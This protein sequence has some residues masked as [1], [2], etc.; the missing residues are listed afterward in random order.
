MEPRRFLSYS[1]ASD[2]TAIGRVSSAE[3]FV[4]LGSRL[5]FRGGGELWQTDGTPGSTGLLRDI[6]PDGASDPRL[7]TVLNG[8]AFFFATDPAHGRELW[9]TDGTTDG[10]RL[11][12]DITPGPASTNAL[13]MA[14]VNGRLYFA[15]DSG[16]QQRPWVSDGTAAGTY[17]LLPGHTNLFG[18]VN[19]FFAFAGKTYFFVGGGIFSIDGT[20]EGT[21]LAIPISAGFKRHEPTVLGD[22]F[23]FHSSSPDGIY[24][25]DGTPEGTRFIRTNS[26]FAPGPDSLSLY[27][28]SFVRIGNKALFVGFSADTGAEPWIT[29]GTVEGTRLVADIRPGPEGSMTLNTNINAPNEQVLPFAG[30]VFL[31]A[32]DGVH[33]RELWFT[34]GTAVGTR[35]LADLVPGPASLAPT[36]GAVVEDTAFFTTSLGLLRTDGTAA[37]TA[38]VS[39]I[40]PFDRNRE[41]LDDKLVFTTTGGTLYAISARDDKPPGVLQTVK[42]FAG[43]GPFAEIEFTEDVSAS[44]T[45]TAFRLLNRDTGQTVSVQQV[46]AVGPTR[47]RVELARALPEGNYMLESIPGAIRDILGNPLSGTL[48]LEGHVLHGDVDGNRVVTDFDVHRFGQVFN[49]DAAFADFDGSGRV[50]MHDFAVLCANYGRTLPPPGTGVAPARAG[51]LFAELDALMT[52]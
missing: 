5:L 39:A 22:R 46:R 4:Q 23:V 51:G 47:I 29:D 49:T 17:Q 16:G 18:D 10:T 36:M 19:D 1:T 26:A 14:A 12:V 40:K 52:R 43:R 2:L 38:V 21:R 45:P 3:S 15:T 25:S 41:V 44:T 6:N 37:R 34:D 28:Q 48:R 7:F 11:A 30:G 35:L 8:R 27:S 31:S 9:Q 20:V 33:G 32:D 50:D 13:L 24:A 42:V